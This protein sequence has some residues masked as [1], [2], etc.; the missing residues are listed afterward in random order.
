M[1]VSMKT[2]KGG[3]LTDQVQRDMVA[4]E[5]F[6]GSRDFFLAYELLEGFMASQEVREGRAP[7]PIQS[8]AT[9]A[10]LALE[11]ALK[12][13]IVI[14]GGEPPS[15]GA[16]GHRYVAMFA[17]LS[18]SAQN[19][20]ARSLL[21]DGQPSTVEKLVS[22]LTEFEGT[23]Q[24][25]RYMHEHL[26]LAFHQGNMVAVIH[27]VYESIVRQR[28]DLGP[29]PGVIVDPDRPSRWHLTPRP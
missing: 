27:G 23:F 10:A 13:R 15:K 25:W 3:N 9:C 28:P 1:M 22:V 24:R 2:T 11:L 4:A 17:L 16:D 8:E 26:E 18:P 20:I 7:S 29:W 6:R 21:V 12:A 14:D 19:D 5:M